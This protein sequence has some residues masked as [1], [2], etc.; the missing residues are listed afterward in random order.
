MRELF[1][2]SVL[3]NRKEMARLFW[4]ESKEPMAAALFASK[5]LKTMAEKAG[6]DSDLGKELDVHAE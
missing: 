1:K 4:E 2:L 6:E 5:M 3:L